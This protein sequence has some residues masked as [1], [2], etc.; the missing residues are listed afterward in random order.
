M[1]INER[2][3]LSMKIG[4]RAFIVSLLLLLSVSFS[5][6][7]ETDFYTEMPLHLRFTQEAQKEILTEDAY[8]QRTYPHTA[9]DG[10]TEEMRLLIDEMTERSRD[11]LPPGIPPRW[12]P[13]PLRCSRG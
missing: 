13:P 11:L 2:N 12:N 6:I 3:T 4:L 8:V 1:H 5:A 9:H 10:V 7:G